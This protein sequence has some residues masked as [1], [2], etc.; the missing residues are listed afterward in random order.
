M[1]TGNKTSKNQLHHC[2]SLAT[3]SMQYAAR[4]AGSPTAAAAAT[5]GS[6]GLRAAA[7]TAG[8]SRISPRAISCFT[9]DLAF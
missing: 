3:C 7:T 8:A 9:A 5:A 4:T 6:M 2:R 1:S